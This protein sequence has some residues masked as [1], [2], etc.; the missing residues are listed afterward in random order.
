M[1]SFVAILLALSLW[2]GAAL[3]RTLA[4]SDTL[5]A[6]DADA[7][8]DLLI[9]ASAR[10]AYWP[11]SEQFVTQKTQAFC[12]VASIVMVLNALGLPAPTTPEYA[13]YH[14]FTQD[15][16][17]TPDT[18]AVLPQAVLAHR[19][20]TLDQLGR[21][22]DVLG[23]R[24]EVHHAADMSLD[25]FRAAAVGALSA[26]DRYVVVNYLRRAIGQESGGHISPLAAY[27]APSDRFLILDVARYKYPP[28][29]VK[30]ADLY[31]AM[32]TLDADNDNRSRGFV[33]ISAKQDSVQ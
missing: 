23:T 28:V 8:T 14:V 31:A 27:H 1:T 10:Q 2:S 33:L 6:L 24:A 7:G 29:W 16:V 12:G 20:M 25:A 32:N 11:L 18:E 15:D 4:L 22:L 17:F 13:P 3:P 21:L 19:G 30:A 26:K 5:V 9:G